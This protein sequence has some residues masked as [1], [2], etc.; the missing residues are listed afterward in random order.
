MR[1]LLKNI[2]I[3]C[4]IAMCI[5][6]YEEDKEIYFTTVS[7]EDD[8]KYVDSGVVLDYGVSDLALDRVKEEIQKIPTGLWKQY[9]YDGGKI[10]IANEKAD[11]IVGSFSVINE[12]D[13][14]ITI[15]E[16]YI[17]YSLCHEFT[18][19]LQY[20]IDI[21]SYMGYSSMLEEKEEIWRE[22]MLSNEYF[23]SESEY[24]AEAG[25]LYLRGE[26][27]PERYPKTIDFFNI[28]FKKYE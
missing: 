10:K 4:F 8:M 20:L 26:I 28:I 12:V 21:K 11:N 18:H 2:L 1:S 22:Y 7:L 25:K 14:L 27:D 13:M 3:L 16:D 5:V 9:F 23:F 19:Y 6:A 15:H 24:F 17:E